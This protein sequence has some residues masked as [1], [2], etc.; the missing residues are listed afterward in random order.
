MNQLNFGN[1]ENNS[2]M[3]NKLANEIISKPIPTIKELKTKILQD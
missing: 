1:K 3:E 2:H